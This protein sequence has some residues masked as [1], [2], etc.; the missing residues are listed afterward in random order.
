MFLD[1]SCRFEAS[2]GACEKITDRELR[3]QTNSK[4]ILAYMEM[5]ETFK[6]VL[7]N[8]KTKGQ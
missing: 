7:Q 4:L 6:D 1:R 8:G 3:D 2:I 5:S